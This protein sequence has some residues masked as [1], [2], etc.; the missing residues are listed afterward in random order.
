MTGTDGT[1]QTCCRPRRRARRA[2]GSDE[3]CA[4][5]TS[6]GARHRG[7]GH[8]LPEIA[9][10]EER[11]DTANRARGG[12]PD[13]PHRA[14]R[15]ARRLRRGARARPGRA[16]R[17]LLAA[18]LHLPAA[19]LART[20]RGRRDL[21]QE[22]FVSALERRLFRRYD[23]RRGRFRTYLRACLDGS[24]A[25]ARKA[26]ARVRR[27]GDAHHLP[28]DFAGAEAE[29]ARAG[30]PADPEALFH[31]RVGAVAVRP[32]RGRPG[33]TRR[34]AGREVAFALS[35]ATTSRGTTP[36]HGPPTPSSPPP[37]T[38]RRPR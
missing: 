8:N 25:N 31:A 2:L 33:G 10:D 37:T 17:R 18:G 5:S 27:G 1:G 3:I 28:L 11:P 6:P 35:R 19:A 29:L 34:T 38:C 4:E 15:R 26:A 9:M 13:A 36:R 20:R 12:S 30:A 16:G 23:P 22:F 21:T 7:V 24:A 32:R 14:R